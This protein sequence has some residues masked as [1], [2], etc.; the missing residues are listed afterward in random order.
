MFSKLLRPGL[1]FKA[2][3]HSYAEKRWTRMRARSDRDLDDEEKAK[4]IAS[5]AL[6]RK[7]MQR[8]LFEMGIKM[9]KYEA[10]FILDLV[11]YCPS[12]TSI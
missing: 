9:K 10:S 3:F 7:D 4:M 11:M 5:L 12:L 2:A 6:G 1:D 8:L